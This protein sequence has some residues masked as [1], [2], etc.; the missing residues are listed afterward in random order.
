MSFKDIYGHEKQILV[1]QNAALRNRLSHAYLFHG[2]EGIGKRTVAEIFAKALNCETREASGKGIVVRDGDFD[3]CDNCPSCFKADRKNHSDIVAI[4]AD[5]QFIRVK[6]IRDL[7]EQMKFAPL[8]GKM[9][10]FI[11]ADADRMNI[12]SANAL[13]K[14]LEEPSRSNLLILL[15]SSPHQLPLTILSRC[16]PVRFNPLQRDTVASF[17]QDRLSMEAERARSIAS[18]SGGSIGKA[19]EMNDD[20]YMTRRDE[21]LQ[22]IL[23]D[24]SKD[25]LKFP[26]MVNSFGQE[27]EDIADRLNIL[28][29]GYRDAL[30]Y[31]E[32]GDDQQLIN[33]QCTEVVKSVARGLSGK[34]ILQNIRNVDWAMHAID[35]N[36]NKKLTLEVMLFKLKRCR[37]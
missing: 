27:R 13:L 28:L 10:I 5:G 29:T 37:G 1:L 6:E 3:S 15:T 22:I 35:R 31:K 20:S 11:M 26:S 30:I 16:Q 33:Q 24:H 17:L 4:K 9:R 23:T 32:M 34:E 19:L 36:A 18:S 21:I 12:I 25:P 2:M 14:T 8:E 7:Q